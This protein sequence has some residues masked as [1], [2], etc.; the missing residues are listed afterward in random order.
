[1]ITSD[2]RC[3]REI[4]SRILMA[5]ETF[6]KKNILLTCKLELNL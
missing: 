5:E 2:A 1:M 3:P 4:K 6:S